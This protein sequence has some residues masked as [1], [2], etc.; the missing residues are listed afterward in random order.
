MS[1][2]DGSS[3]HL[4]LVVEDDPDIA[5]GLQVALEGEGYKVATAANGKEAL[6]RL[7]ELGQPCL[8]LLDLMM[9]VMSGGEF[10][11]ALRRSDTELPVVVVSAWPKEA[12]KVRAQTQG[13]V[14]KPVSLEALLEVTQKFC[15]L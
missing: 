1:H 11:M 2:S 15:A 12:E 10:L 5:D 4:I 13:F 14:K 3:E 6:A 8:V 7:A 9:P